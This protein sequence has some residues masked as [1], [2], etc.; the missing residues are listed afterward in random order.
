MG[1]AVNNL[2]K[3]YLIFTG[4][5]MKKNNQKS[6]WI[7]DAVLFGGLICAFF[8]DET[9]LPFHQWLGIAVGALANYHLISHWR[10]VKATAGKFFTK[11]AGRSRM[12]LVIDTLMAVGLMTIVTT[13]VIMSTWLNLNLANYT[14]WKTVHIISS[15]TTLLVTLIKIGLHWKWIVKTAHRFSFKPATV[16]PQLAVARIPAATN[17]GV[18]RREFLKMMGVI[19]VATA[20]ASFKAISE[21]EGQADVASASQADQS[22]SVKSDSVQTETP[23][24]TTP[25]SQPT[26]MTAEEVEPVTVLQQSNTDATNLTISEST[27]SCIPQCREK[28]SY[29]GRCRKYTDSNGNGLCDNG[30]CL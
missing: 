18:G 9:G 5:I 27:M 22:A 15:V 2:L 12:C 6:F 20:L 3:E 14:V 19:G 11:T 4:T 29:P 28:C 30:E 17:D 8:M 10:W 24:V 21:L 26:S 13:G 16:Y 1:I 7:I 25:Q 23:N